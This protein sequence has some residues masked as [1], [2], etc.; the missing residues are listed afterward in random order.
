MKIESLNLKF[1]LKNRVRITDFNKLGTVIAVYIS[2]V[3]IQY[4]VRF[5][6]GADFKTCY[7]FEEELDDQV[8]KLKIQRLDFKRVRKKKV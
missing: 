3:G 1:Y 5:Y 8:E 7:F 2:D 4:F 6:D